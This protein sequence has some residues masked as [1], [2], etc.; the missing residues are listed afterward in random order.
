VGAIVKIPTLEP[1]WFPHH[2]IPGGPGGRTPDGP[3][4]R[5]SLESVLAFPSPPQ[6]GRFNPPNVPPPDPEYDGGGPLRRCFFEGGTW[7]SR[8]ATFPPRVPGT[9]PGLSLAHPRP[10]VP[11]DA[12]LE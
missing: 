8:P 10:P 12:L 2:P 9:G 7:S 11:I 5:T 1:S 3:D 6:G 4:L